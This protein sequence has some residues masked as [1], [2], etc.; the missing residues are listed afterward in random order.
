MTTH[1]GH[2]LQSSINRRTVLKTV[3]IG[4]VA[5]LAAVGG[6]T[7]RAFAQPAGDSVQVMLDVAATAEAL[8]T[9]LLHAL[10][11]RATYFGQLPL[12]HQEV[13]RASL[14]TELAH[15]EA[16]TA[17]GG[18]P[19]L[20]SFF[21]PDGLLEDLR[22]FVTLG[23]YLETVCVGAYLA[24][25]RRFAEL[26]M[27]LMSEVASQFG[28]SEAEHRVLIR[29]LG[30]DVLN[31][32]ILP[33][34]IPWERPTLFQASQAQQFLAPFLVGGTAFERDFDN[35][36]AMPSRAA[37]LAVALPQEPVPL[38]TNAF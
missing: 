6:A 31:L 35:V 34:N 5:A 7:P 30:R 17:Q 27:P 18:K 20:T 29:A 26:G 2:E 21:M 15:L 24:A 3:G 1:D 37:V 8:G 25:T 14:F 22:L 28:G 11:T 36:M 23:D 4:G 33:N 9:T 38:A 32:A 16:L 13:L 10:I 12:M 19:L